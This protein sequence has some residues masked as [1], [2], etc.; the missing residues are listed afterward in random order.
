MDDKQQGKL[1]WR[2]LADMRDEYVAMLQINL[3]EPSDFAKLHI[4]DSTD[5]AVVLLQNFSKFKEIYAAAKEI[6]KPR[7]IEQQPFETLNEYL[8][9][10]TV[11]DSA[12]QCARLVNNAGHGTIMR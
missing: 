9:H 6:K 10:H 8:E 7:P 3:V 4:D 2:L 1:R 11:G 12:I 5:H